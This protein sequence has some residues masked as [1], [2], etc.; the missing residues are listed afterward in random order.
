MLDK[1]KVGLIVGLFLAAMHAAWALAVAIIPNALQSFLDWIFN[2]HFLQPIWKLT[3][4]NFVDAIFLVIVTFIAGYISG[5]V[6][7]WVYNSMYKKN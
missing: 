5:W 1:N 6:F 3:A 4:F 7:A 2:I